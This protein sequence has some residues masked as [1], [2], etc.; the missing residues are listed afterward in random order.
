MIFVFLFLTFPNSLSERLLMSCLCFPF[1]YY[2]GIIC[3]LVSRN[4]MKDL[5]KKQTWLHSDKV[6]GRG[7]KAGKAAG[8]ET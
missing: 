6:A 3:W 8:R 4:V 7:W 5:K 1:S 2:P